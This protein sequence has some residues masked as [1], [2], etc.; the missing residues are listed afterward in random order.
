MLL[1]QLGDLQARPGAL[2]HRRHTGRDVHP[3]YLLLH[4]R[5]Q[6]HV[7]GSSLGPRGIQPLAI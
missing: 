3:P 5:E 7:G 6:R 1:Q 2:H 4:R